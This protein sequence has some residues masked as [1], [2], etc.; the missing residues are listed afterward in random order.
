MASRGH[1]QPSFVGRTA[2]APGM[3][4]HGPFPGSG[5]TVAHRTLETAIHPNIAEGK[6][7]AQLAEIEGL[8]GDNHRLA[9]THGA[10]RQELAASQH[11][12]SKIKAHI[13]SIETESDIQIRVLVER[14]AKM[15]GDIRVSER[16]KKELQQAHMQAQSLVTAKQELTAQV[17][18]ATRDLHKANSDVKRLPELHAELDS[19]KQEHQ[20]LR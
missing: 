18:L 8:I 13:R 16:V 14:I 12:I 11:E 20:S 2:Q 17:H 10:L 7:L 19:M 9:A 4:R 5:H 3:M 6:M 1:Q 15:E